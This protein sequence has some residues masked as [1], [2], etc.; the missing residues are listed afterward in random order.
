MAELGIEPEPLA[1]ESDALPTAL[2]GRSFFVR[3]IIFLKSATTRPEVCKKHKIV[4]EQIQRKKEREK[5][6]STKYLKSI[7]AKFLEVNLYCQLCPEA[8][9]EL[10]FRFATLN[11][12]G[13]PETTNATENSKRY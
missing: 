10:Q 1:L 3:I 5:K 11:H 12:I 13:Y 6:L 7:P 9:E 8:C 2:R 4:V